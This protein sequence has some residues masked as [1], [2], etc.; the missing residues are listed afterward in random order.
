MSIPPSKIN[1]LLERVRKTNYDRYLRSVNLVKVRALTGQRVSF[2]FPVTALIGTNGGGK[3][4]IL[5]AAATAYKN[6]K[7]GTFFPKSNIGDDSMQNWSI[8]YEIIDRKINQSAPIKRTAS[9]KNY[10]WN[11]DRFFARDILEFPISRTVPAGERKNLKKYVGSNKKVTPRISNLG[12]QVAKIASR[13]LAKDLSKFEHALLTGKDDLYI[14][15]IGGDRY[16]EFH[17]GAGESSI[18]RMIRQIESAPD[19]S[20]IIIE[21]IEN[22]LHPKATRAMVEYLLDVADRKRIQAIFTT[23]SEYALAPLPPEAVWASA[24]GQVV[25]GKLSIDSLRAMVGDVPE[26]IAVFVEDTFAQTFVQAMLRTH[27]H[28]VA[29]AIGI[30]PV[31]SYQNV[32]RTHNAHVSNPAITSKSLAMVDGDAEVEEDITKN[33]YKLPGEMPEAMVFD[34]A[35][36]NIDKL[37]AKVAMRCQIS[38]GQQDWLI[39]K[40]K[41]IS[42]SNHDRHTVF[43]DLGV[44]L[45]FT[46]E[47]VIRGAFI[48]TWIEDHVS[49]CK[50]IASMIASHIR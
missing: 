16:T 36:N 49:E 25:Q 45:D 2:D 47:S 13:I 32:I 30:Y 5:G 43:S 41:E 14:G 17:F 40:V 4:T 18:I 20:L 19:S 15:S 3:S 33:I 22:G 46:A 7:P 26:R 24:D 11:R 12:E 27:E 50:A 28:D 23:H 37:S 38:H 48:A 10:K 34:Y 42:L 29:D 35:A 31:G 9:F 44:A 8:E 1:D 39:T 6:V 21:E